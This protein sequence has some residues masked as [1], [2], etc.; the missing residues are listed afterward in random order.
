[1]ASLGTSALSS[2]R[3]Q[4]SRCSCPEGCSPVSTVDLGAFIVQHE[5]WIC[6]AR[7]RIGFPL[8]SP[9]KNLVAFRD[10]E[11]LSRHVVTSSAKSKVTSFS[12][13]GCSELS[14][15][16]S[17]S[18]TE[19]SDLIAARTSPKGRLLNSSCHPPLDSHDFG[20]LAGR[21]RLRGHPAC[22]RVTF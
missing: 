3:F 22:Q 13:V 17:F 19:S 8:G 7:G 1:M 11:Y 14:A 18:A 2:K 12:S 16:T 10:C 9:L 6:S 5:I 21:D 20:L 15:S 4:A